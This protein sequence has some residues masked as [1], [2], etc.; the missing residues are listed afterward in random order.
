MAAHYAVPHMKKVGGGAIVNVSSVHALATCG[1]Y[2]VYAA[3][4]GG[5]IAGTRGLAIELAPFNIRANVISPGAI[6]V[7][8]QAEAIGR[9][10]GQQRKTEFQERFGDFLTERYRYYQDLNITGLP[11]DIAH[12]ALYLASDESRF[13]TGINITVDGGLTAKLMLGSDISQE[14]QRQ[15][16]EMKQWVAR[17]GERE[18]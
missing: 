4:K 11:E 8:E 9:Q 3:S 15:E 13:V 2:S 12:A 17:L 18:G 10:Y 7:Y 16:Q 6:E 5:M 14:L 1:A